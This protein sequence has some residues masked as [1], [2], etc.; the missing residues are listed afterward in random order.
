MQVIG[1]LIFLLEKNQNR[2]IW[3]YAF[4]LFYSGDIAA[5]G[6]D[7]DI[8]RVF[9]GKEVDKKINASGCCILPGKNE[10]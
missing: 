10:F 7:D 5:I 9:E 3:I 2:Q 1:L 4:V 6:T 8:V